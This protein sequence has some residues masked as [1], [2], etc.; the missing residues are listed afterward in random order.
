M[1]G[2][3]IFIENSVLGL[4]D[5]KGLIRGFKINRKMIDDLHT[6]LFIN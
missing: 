5:C 2:C 3:D 4:S 1:S 6:F